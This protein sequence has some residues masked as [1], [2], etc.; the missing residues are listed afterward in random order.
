MR[1]VRLNAV[2]TP[3]INLGVHGSIVVVFTVG[4]MRIADR[5]LS[6]AGFTSYL[7][8]L[9]YLISPLVVLLTSL[10]NVQRGLAA[11]ARVT[12]LIDLP[13]ERPGDHGNLPRGHLPPDTAPVLAFESVSFG[14]CP[15][16]PVW[17][18]CRSPLWSED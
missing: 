7:L 12:E 5:E 4:T 3:L 1:A 17:T 11:A 14:Y 8:Y 10:A 13:E 9:F 6:A 18:P 16:R 15:D 2:F